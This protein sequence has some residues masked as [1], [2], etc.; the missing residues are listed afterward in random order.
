MSVYSSTV[1]FNKNRGKRSNSDPAPKIKD[2]LITIKF[3]RPLMREFSQL[4]RGVSN[5]FRGHVDFL[6]EYRTDDGE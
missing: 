2:M 1:R 3:V 4:I 6:T 5:I